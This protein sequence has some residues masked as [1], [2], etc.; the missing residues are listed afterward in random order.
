MYLVPP[1]LQN[2]TGTALQEGIFQKFLQ[3]LSRRFFILGIFTLLGDR[4]ISGTGT[5]LVVPLNISFILPKEEFP[6]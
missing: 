3:G 5:E 1:T 6:R 4:S 2:A